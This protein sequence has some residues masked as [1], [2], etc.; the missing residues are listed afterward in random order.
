MMGIVRFFCGGA[1]R[2]ERLLLIQNAKFKFQSANFGK[3]TLP[4]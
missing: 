2:R 3:N 4:F 1:K